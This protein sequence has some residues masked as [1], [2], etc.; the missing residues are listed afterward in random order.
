MDVIADAS[1]GPGGNRTNNVSDV[2]ILQTASFTNLD[3]DPNRGF[4]GIF[5]ETHNRKELLN[6]Y[7]PKLLPQIGLGGSKPKN[8]LSLY[9]L[10][11]FSFL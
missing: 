10:L 2:T 11:R 3:T 8:S 7:Q 9:F 1:G 5:V 6:L 4:P